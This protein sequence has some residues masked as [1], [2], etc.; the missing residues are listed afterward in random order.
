MSHGNSVTVFSCVCQEIER[1]GVGGFQAGHQDRVRG[2]VVA[3][4]LVLQVDA[5]LMSLVVE[6][7]AS[8]LVVHF[9]MCTVLV[10]ELSLWKG[11]YRCA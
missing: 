7:G 4:I 10:M 5:T 6:L 3:P 1:F 11:Q 2:R 9:C 8:Y